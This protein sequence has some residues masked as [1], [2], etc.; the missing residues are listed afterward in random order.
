MV[1]SCL[2][3][4]V[5]PCFQ[6]LF[7]VPPSSSQPKLITRFIV[8]AVCRDAALSPLLFED[9]TGFH[10]FIA[11]LAVNLHSVSKFYSLH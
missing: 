2:W 5:N 9:Q 8:D 6:K 10:L 3:E 4:G 11:E 7:S 1:L